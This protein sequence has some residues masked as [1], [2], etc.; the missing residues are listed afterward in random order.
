M[1]TYDYYCT[2]QAQNVLG[3]TNGISNRDYLDEDIV[4]GK[5]GLAFSYP[6]IRKHLYFVLDDGWDVPY[7]KNVNEPYPFASHIIR[8]DRFPS[9]IGTPKEKLKQMVDKIKNIGWKGL[10]IWVCAQG[11]DNDYF[12]TINGLKD[13]FKTRLE[14]SKYAKV[15]YWK[16]DWGRYDN[17]YAFRKM[18]TTLAKQIYPELIIENARCL[19]P[20]NGF[21][22]GEEPGFEYQYPW[23]KKLKRYIDKTLK[24]SEVF[25]SYD[26]TEE[27]ETTT[28]I[29]RLSY[30]LKNNENCLINCEDQ[31]YLGAVL[32]LPVGIMRNRLAAI[33]DNTK[34]C[35]YRQD[36]AIATINFRKIAPVFKGTKLHVSKKIF[37]DHHVFGKYWCNEVTDHDVIQ[38]APQIISR[39]ME[40]PKVIPVGDVPYV[41]CAKHRNGIYAIGTY[42]R[43]CF[44]DDHYSIDISLNVDGIKKIGVFSNHIRKL[45]L[46]HT[47][48]TNKLYTT[49]LVS[50][51]KSN[52]TKYCTI[53]NNK[54]IVDYNKII[55][56]FKCDDYSDVAFILE[57]K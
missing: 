44:E 13:F 46:N 34:R 14:W 22:N 6:S 4:F 24:I 27:L 47:P 51:R 56:L 32:G 54:I 5:H 36:E 2:W 21:C 25:R 26:C 11:Y 40:L 52:V 45:I 10:G 42:K 35:H 50:M 1:R 7:G 41:A 29:K 37:E 31:L 33:L 48:I 18:L 28:T 15:S 20:V 8:D 12:K 16:V 9:F 57:L 19:S 17:Y 55:P 23:N 39:N 30:L 49:N 43:L 38:Q 3:F 53:Y